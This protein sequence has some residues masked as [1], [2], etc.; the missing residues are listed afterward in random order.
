MKKRSTAIIL[1]L[2]AAALYAINIP[3]SKLL[4]ANI[5]P[6]A[7]ASLLYL[8]AGL[9]MAVTSIATSYAKKKSSLSDPIRILFAKGNRIYTVGM[10][11]LD[12][13]APIFLMYGIKY[14]NSSNVSLLNNLEIAATSLIALIIFKEKISKTLFCGIIL[15]IISGGLLSYEGAEGLSFSIDSLFVIAA[16]ICWGLENNCTKKLSHNDSNAI[17]ITKGIFSGIGSLTLAIVSKESFPHIIYIIFALV[18]G[19]IAYGLSIKL[20]VMAQN[21]IGAAKTRAFYSVSP[22]LGVFFSFVFLKETAS[23][24]FLYALVTMVLAT[25]VIIFDTMRE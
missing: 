23:P 11:I 10:V 14:A 8:G 25:A 21:V 3:F 2:T 17:V 16:C 20:Y 13:A 15:V 9:G 4:L 22:F 7:L 24:L 5:G 6:T 12:I 1:A 18:L 19:Y